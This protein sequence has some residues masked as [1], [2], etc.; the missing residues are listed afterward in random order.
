MTTF[1]G[2]K[3]SLCASH[4][5]FDHSPSLLLCRQKYMMEGLCVFVGRGRV[6]IYQVHLL[7][8]G[9]TVV[10]MLDSSPLKAL[11]ASG[12]TSCEAL[13]NSQLEAWG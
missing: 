8:V 6:G 5:G 4:F 2:R 11:R 1:N 7:E 10:A 13:A 3:N 12:G 9:T